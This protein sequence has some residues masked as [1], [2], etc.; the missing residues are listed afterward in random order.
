MAER[1]ITEQ[2]IYTALAH[3]QRRTPG[4]PGT[5]W[6]H[7]L[8]GQGRTLKICVTVDMSTVVTAAWPD[9]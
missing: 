8:T 6:I 5:V 7:G 1:G 4:Q 9:E 3:E 2:Q